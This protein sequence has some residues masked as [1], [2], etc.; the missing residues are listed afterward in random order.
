M[1][2]PTAIWVTCSKKWVD[3]E[4]AE[5]SFNQAIAVMPDFAE[6]HYNLGNVLK[7]LGRLDE[8]EASYNQAIALK[9]YFA[10]SY[11]ITWGACFKN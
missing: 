5:A 7:D 11:T 4:D 10:D 6:A 1:L 2:K 8:A 3:W 9:P